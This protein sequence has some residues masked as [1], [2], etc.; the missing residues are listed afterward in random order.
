MAIY[1]GPGGAGD[2]TGDATNASALALAAKDEAQASATSAA[3]SATA[4]G[5]SATAADASAT[6]AATQA[7]NAAGS[8][9]SAA[10]SATNASNSATAASSSATTAASEASDAADSATAAASSATS[11]STDA[12]TAS[13]QATNAA[14]SASS[15]STSASTATTKASEAS[16]SATNAASSATT[17]STAATNA[18]NSASAAA[19]SETNAA[20]SASSASTSASNASTSASTATTQATNASS[21]A[22]AASTSASNAATAA[23][24]AQT[25]E[26][27]AETAQAAAESA[28]DATLAAYDSFDDRYLGAKVADPVLDNDGNALAAGE[29][30]FNTIS[31]SMKVYTGTLWV[32]SYADGNTLLA[33]AANLSDLANVAT[34][35]TNLGLVIGTNVQ[36]Y[37]ADLAAIAS[38]GKG[39]ELASYGTYGV[40]FKN[41]IINGQMMI[42]QRNAGASVTP[43]AGAYTVDR[44]AASVSQASKLTFQQNYGGLTGSNLPV[45]FTKYLGVY[46]ASAHSIGASD[47][48]QLAQPIEGLNVSDFGWG[49]SSAA[50][51][52]L[53]FLV[54]SSLTGTF[55][56]AVK[57]S[58]SNRSYPFSY[59][60]SAANTWE[61]KTV[62]IAG[63]TSGTWLTDTG[64]GLN[65]VFG[66][67]MGS[68]YSG[69][70]GAWASANYGSATGATSVV[71]TSGATFYITGVQLEKGSTATSFD[72]R[73]YG[74]E[75]QL[76]KRYLPIYNS[77]TANS[78][79]V[80]THSLFSTTGGVAQ[81]IFDVEP[82][83]PPSGLSVTG[84]FRATIPGNNTWNIT[85]TLAS[86]SL[87]GATLNLAGSGMS[88]G[89]GTLLSN[90]LPAQLQFTGCEL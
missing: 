79:P 36:A 27:N 76:C 35:R 38:S 18:S 21:S 24:N 87:K 26:T 41:R 37:D 20:S 74:T 83:V 17:A 40:G 28:R 67:G 48:F 62:T 78:E 81:F 54:R 14:S 25:A 1:R 51:V 53:S 72:Y 88:T 65:L 2:A 75:L 61:Q 29:L 15:A 31:N 71:G 12:S 56:G 77:T 63:D 44:W 4:A 57:N 47:Y 23:T 68:T 66:L 46:T 19:T 89:F 32:D 39:A 64:I 11:A 8:A 22:S 52:T 59:S 3:S 50:T 84:T 58:A 69:A 30:Y 70:A 80:G 49:T 45:G 10:T 9:T 5:N 55:G 85:P 7:T 13:T 73:P 34:A 43:T 86:S 42:D 6:S 60:I 82:R 33:K 16:T 90:S